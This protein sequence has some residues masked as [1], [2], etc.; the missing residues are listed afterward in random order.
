MP[1]LRITCTSA[2]TGTFPMSD[3]SWL[4]DSVVTNVN[5]HFQ[6][7]QPQNDKRIYLRPNPM[8]LIDHKSR[9]NTLD[10]TIWFINI[11]TFSD[12]CVIWAILSNLADIDFPMYIVNCAGYFLM[13]ESAW[14]MFV[15]YSEPNVSSLNNLSAVIS[16]FIEDR[17]YEPKFHVLTLQRQ[18]C[19]L[20]LYCNFIRLAL[21]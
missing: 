20:H 17:N 4:S 5:W 13:F 9:I 7:Y 8:F 1:G 15:P 18:L 21:Y 14:K 12:V 6:K 2:N 16:L 3:T 11:N 10:Q 19:L